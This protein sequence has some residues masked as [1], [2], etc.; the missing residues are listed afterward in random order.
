[1]S[2]NQGTK[3]VQL[4][5]KHSWYG[6]KQIGVMVYTGIMMLIGA[7]VVGGS[8]NTVIPGISAVRGFDVNTM[9]FWAGIGAALAAVGNLFFA[10][11]MPKLRPK[12]T[13][14][15]TLFITALCLIVFGSTSSA[16]LFILMIL[17]MGFVSGGYQLSGTNALTLNWWPTKKGAVL[18]F[19]TIGYVLM[20]V[21]YVP[22][23]PGAYERFG[24]FATHTAVAVFLAVMGL[25]GLAAIKDTPE[26]AG[27]YPDGDVKYA[28]RDASTVVEEMRQY[29]SPFTLG[30]M[31]KT[32]STWTISIGFFLCYVAVMMFIGSQIPMLLSFGYSFPQASVIFAV[33]G[34]VA[35]AGSVIIGMLDQKFGTKTASKIYVFFLIIGF[36]F[37]L[38]SGSSIAFAWIGGILLKGT[39]G[40]LMNLVPSFVGTKYGRWD[41]S[42]AYRVIGTI[43]QVGGGLGIS[44]ISFFSDAKTMYGFAIGILIIA[45]I[46]MFVSDDRFVGKAG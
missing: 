28:D 15:I 1:M 18:G 12:R 20:G 5:G 27:T 9:I 4:K 6:S 41:Y 40:G 38:F 16:T 31:L 37:V 22:Y 32:P 3:E 36:I 42:A 43:V 19:T 46:L 35:I 11:M 23:I 26:E 30:K 14:Y 10:S 45:L 34:L 29:K 8:T 17:I 21:V 7:C 13:I 25:I 39:N 2:T 33:T 44:M 24:V